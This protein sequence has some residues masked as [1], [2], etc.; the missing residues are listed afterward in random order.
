MPTVVHTDRAQ[1]SFQH[2]SKAS[3]ALLCSLSDE[4]R[5]PQRI[6]VLL[7]AFSFLPYAHSANSIFQSRD[8]EIVQRVH[9]DISKQEAEEPSEIA[10]GRA[11]SGADSIRP[12]RSFLSTSTA[13]I[14]A[15]RFAEGLVAKE[16]PWPAAKVSLPVY[17]I[18]H[19]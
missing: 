17:L 10:L 4:G 18:L 12:L 7:R 15:V 11:N 9:G 2:C 16:R 3:C 13:S 1:Q 5:A 19:Y 8:Q 14:P 6:G